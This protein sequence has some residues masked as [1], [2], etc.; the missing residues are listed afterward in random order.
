[1]AAGERYYLQPKCLH[2]KTT[3]I[4]LDNNSITYLHEQ[5]R[6]N[7]KIYHPSR[8]ECSYRDISKVQGFYLLAILEEHSLCFE[9][10]LLSLMTC[11]NFSVENHDQN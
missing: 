2:D 3:N 9:T 5:Q 8:D 4:S 10:V 1:M 7:Y 11:N 6:V